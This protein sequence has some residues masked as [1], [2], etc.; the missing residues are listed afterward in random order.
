MYRP[1]ASR[2]VRYADLDIWPLKIKAGMWAWLLH[3][4]TGLAIVFYLFM[5]IIVISTVIWGR[6]DATMAFLKSPVFVAGELLLIAAGLFHGLNGI[7]IILF[8]L[9]LG[10][11]SQKGMFAG[12]L[13]LSVI[14]FGWAAKVFWP[15]IFG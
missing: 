1:V 11:K 12:V 10:I 15:L 5:H 14:G 9:G 8:D 2:E 3:R 4:I 13:V 6:F 7:R